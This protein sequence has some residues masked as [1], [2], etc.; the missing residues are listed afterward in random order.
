MIE[1]DGLYYE[2]LHP[3]MYETV[4]HYANFSMSILDI[5]YYFE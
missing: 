4:R 3:R 1:I 5:C 2:Y